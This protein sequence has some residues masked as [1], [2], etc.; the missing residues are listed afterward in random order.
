[1]N[2]LLRPRQGG[3]MTS[4]IFLSAVVAWAIQAGRQ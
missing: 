4:V 3:L 1:M 2:R